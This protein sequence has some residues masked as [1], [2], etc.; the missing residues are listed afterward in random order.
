MPVSD[1]AG[2]VVNR[3]SRYA[4][5][6]ISVKGHVGQGGEGTVVKLW[7]RGREDE[8]VHLTSRDLTLWVVAFDLHRP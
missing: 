6:P 8:G 3:P 7:S 5:T 2:V 1:F 4:V